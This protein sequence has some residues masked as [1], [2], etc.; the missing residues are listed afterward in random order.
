MANTELLG[1]RLKNGRE[2]RIAYISSKQVI[3]GAAK[4]EDALIISEAAL[5][6]LLSTS[7]VSPIYNIGTATVSVE[8]VIDADGD[9]KWRSQSGGG[10]SYITAD[11]VGLTLVEFPVGTK[12]QLTFAEIR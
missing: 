11:E 8:G 9:F 6:L 3:F 4:G 2:L 10:S 7:A 12:V 5:D 1:I